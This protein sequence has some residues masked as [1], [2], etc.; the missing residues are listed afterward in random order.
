M[1]GTGVDHVLADAKLLLAVAE[2]V[3]VVITIVE[4]IRRDPKD[5]VLLFEFLALVTFLLGLPSIK[6]S[7]FSWPVIIIWPILFLSFVLA[8]AYFALVNWSHRT[9]GT[10]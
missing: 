6:L 9:K 7:G 8:A 4:A 10:S 3:G 5:R 1:M 2:T